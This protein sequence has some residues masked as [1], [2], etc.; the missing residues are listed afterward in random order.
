MLNLIRSKK[1]YFLVTL[2]LIL[3][4][5]FVENSF[6]Q[7]VVKDGETSI[8]L[9]YAH[10][11]VDTLHNYTD[12]S[13]FVNLPKGDSIKV[14][15]VGYKDTILINDNPSEIKLYKSNNQLQEIVI[16]AKTESRTFGITSKRHDLLYSN[17]AVDNTIPR[18]YEIIKSFEAAEMTFQFLE[19]VSLYSPKVQKNIIFRINVYSIKDGV[20][21]LLE[22]SMIYSDKLKKGMNTILVNQMFLT[23]TN[24]I[25]IGLEWLPPENYKTTIGKIGDNKSS[26]FFSDLDFGG[27]RSEN[28]EQFYRYSPT[29][30]WIR[31]KNNSE[32]II[33]ITTDLY[34][35]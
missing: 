8:G 34:V 4:M 28:S 6:A 23:E 29:D 22:H 3:T 10:I 16:E 11:V 17:G 7:T 32:L 9:A 26:I 19:S 14:S 5:C 12:Q 27:L 24:K 15:Y 35:E 18:Y 20:D 33:E 25:A 31:H 1:S 2:H 21:T 30:D 13:G